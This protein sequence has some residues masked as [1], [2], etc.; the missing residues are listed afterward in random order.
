MTNLFKHIAIKRIQESHFFPTFLLRFHGH[1]IWETVLCLLSFYHFR[2]GGP[3]PPSSGR[4]VPSRGSASDQMSPIRPLEPQ[5]WSDFQECCHQRTIFFCFSFQSFQKFT[6]I[7]SNS[8]VHTQLLNSAIFWAFCNTC[9][10]TCLCAS[11]LMR[12]YEG[13]NCNCIN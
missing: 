2:G 8:F 12:G 10:Y 11:H 5:Q 1:A 7:C 9:P 3:G 4:S 13:V 6:F